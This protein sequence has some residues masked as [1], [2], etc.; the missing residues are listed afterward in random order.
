MRIYDR[1]ARMKHYP[2]VELDNDQP[3]ARTVSR[4]NA[5]IV[6]NTALA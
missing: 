6:F 1:D 3:L 2:Q 5:T 4:V